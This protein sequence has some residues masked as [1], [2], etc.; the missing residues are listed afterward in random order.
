MTAR[1]VKHG[2]LYALP[3]HGLHPKLLSHAANP[4]P[5]HLEG[6]TYRIF[7]SARDKLKRSSVGAVDIDIVSRRVVQQ[8]NQ[9]IL[10]HGA[11]GSFFQDGISLGNWYEACGK[12]YLTFMGWQNPPGGHW[13]GDIGRLVINEDLSLQIDSQTPFMT[14][15][16]A[17][18]LSLSYPWIIKSRADHYDMWYG[19]TLSWNTGNGEMLHVL[20]HAE[21]S[22][23]QSFTRTD[24]TVPSEVGR[25]QAFSR[26]TILKSANDTWDMWFSYRG[27]NG[28]PYRIGHATSTNGLKWALSL[29]CQDLDVCP[30]GWDSDMV[31]YPYVFTHNGEVIMLYNG[32]GYGQ[33][34]FGMAILVA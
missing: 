14:S 6:D 13:R 3:A 16:E 22:D 11:P 29:D 1:W 23:G 26:P 9:P 17:D 2:L 34:G 7:F 20:K 4:T 15:D 10:E 21:S 28:I 19:S 33:S 25:A 8:H 12:R 5:F 30:K 18:P 32:N 27:G 24:H 31:E